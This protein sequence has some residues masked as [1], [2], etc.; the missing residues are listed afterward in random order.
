[1]WNPKVHYLVQKGPLLVW[2]H[3]QI[4][5]I[6]YFYLS[7]LFHIHFNIILPLTIWPST[8]PC[9]PFAY[10]S[11]KSCCLFWNTSACILPSCDSP[12]PISAP[13][14]QQLHFVQ[15][16]TGAPE[17]L[18]GTAA[19]DIA[20]TLH[21]CNFCSLGW[22]LFFEWNLSAISQNVPF[23]ILKIQ[24][25]IK[26]SQLAQSNLCNGRKRR[27]VPTGTSNC[28]TLQPTKVQT[29]LYLHLLWRHRGGVEEQ[30][31]SFLSLC[32]RRRGWV[33]NATFQLLYPP[34]SRPGSAQGKVWTGA[35][36]FAPTRIRTQ[37]RPVAVPTELSRPYRLLQK[38]YICQLQ[39]S[40]FVGQKGQ[41]QRR[42]L[43]DACS[44]CDLSQYRPTRRDA[45]RLS[46]TW[47]ALHMAHY[48]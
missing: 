47:L 28:G 25:L 2:I 21:A 26:P 31:Y 3:S 39:F 4:N 16:A 42:W 22:I 18:K 13:Y 9:S 30:L 20:W 17:V 14:K 46:Y 15:Q 8:K 35:E 11:T 12:V 33:V 27:A 6:Q 41:F 32:A 45:T 10:P 43:C 37:D 5:P 48:S 7:L 24:T 23:D 19:T 40:P 44:C 36:D 29:L 34:A 38:L 1:M